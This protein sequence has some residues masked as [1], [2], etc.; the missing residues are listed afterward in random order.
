MAAALPCPSRAD[1]LQYAATGDPGDAS[2]VLHTGDGEAGV[3]HA[4][5]STARV[6]VLALPGCKAA[7]GGASSQGSYRQDSAPIWRVPVAVA[8]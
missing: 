2:A 8:G 6:R 3:L 4:G 7:S 1:S 5:E